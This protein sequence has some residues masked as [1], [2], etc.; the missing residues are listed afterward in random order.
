MTEGTRTILIGSHSIIHSILVLRA[1]KILYGS[2]PKF[3]QLVCIFIHDIG[4]AGTNYHTNKTNEGHAELGARIARKLFGEKGFNFIAGHSRSTAEKFG[5]PLS[6]LEPPD[7]YSWIIAP[8]WWLRSNRKIDKYAM[9]GEVWQKLV[10]KNWEENGMFNRGPSYKLY[11]D[12]ITLFN[13]K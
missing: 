11:L 6:D 10:T 7:D 13:Q 8:R 9:D 1:W 12:N 2:Y 4:Y 3:W 5:I